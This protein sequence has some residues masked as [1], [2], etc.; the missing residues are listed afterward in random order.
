MKK[1]KDNLFIPSLRIK[2]SDFELPKK[3][4]PLNGHTK[5]CL[6]C[7][8]VIGEEYDACGEC[9]STQSVLETKKKFH[10]NK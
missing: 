7:K 1:K 9:L 8:R 3:Y 4:I 5:L 6:G 10:K 2:K